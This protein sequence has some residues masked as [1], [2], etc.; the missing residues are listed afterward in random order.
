MPW[1]PFEAIHW[2]DGYLRGDMKVFEYGSGGSTVFLAKRAGQVFSVEHDKSWYAQ[3]SETLSRL[4]IENSVY[5][6]REA[7]WNTEG[8]ASLDSVRER[9]LRPDA[10]ERSNPGANFESYVSAIDAH[11]DGNFDL[12]LVDGRARQACIERALRKIH[13]GGYLMLDNSNDQRL[14]DCLSLSCIQA[15]TRKDFH[16]IAP[17]W[18]PKRWTAS[19]WQIT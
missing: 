11:P 14:I 18:P 10:S 4:G 1:L 9:V 6:L 7:V 15:Y 12:V 5:Q 3:V 13:T 8:I 2:L 16:S 17:N 19:L